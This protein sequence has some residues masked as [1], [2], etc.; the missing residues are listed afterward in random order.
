MTSK[1]VPERPR[2]EPPRVSVPHQRANVGVTSAFR[3]REVFG[4]HLPERLPCAHCSTQ[5]IAFICWDTETERLACI[6]CAA[7]LHRL[8]PARFLALSLDAR[9][10]VEGM[11]YLRAAEAIAAL[12]RYGAR[13]V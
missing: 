12:V 4:L 6:R 11:G 9:G 5:L 10:R 1:P 8:D 13:I 2:R 7:A 3:P